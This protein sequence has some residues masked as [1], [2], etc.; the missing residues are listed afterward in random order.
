MP[1]PP[2]LQCPTLYAH[3]LPLPSST[4]GRCP[5]LACVSPVTQLP[6]LPVESTSAA[7]ASFAASPTAAA[8][9]PVGVPGSGTRDPGY[10]R[11]P[12]DDRLWAAQGLDAARPPT[13]LTLHVLTGAGGLGKSAA[14]RELLLRAREVGAYPGGCLWINLDSEA[15]AEASIRDAVRANRVLRDALPPGVWDSNDPAAVVQAVVAWLGEQGRR[16]W[17]AV[18]DNADAP[19]ALAA[20]VARFLPHGGANGHVLITTRLATVP[21]A[22]LDRGCIVDVAAELGL[23]DAILLLLTSLM[24]AVRGAVCCL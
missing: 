5:M 15:T 8:L 7:A 3:P 11:L 13:T 24:R 22:L 9:V 1:V 12:L 10:L 21:E 19:A 20:L 18:F 17:L 2:S 14:A 4:N 16:R 23:G 6:P